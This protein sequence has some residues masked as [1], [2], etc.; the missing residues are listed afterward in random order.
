MAQITY[1]QTRNITNVSGLFEDAERDAQRLWPDRDGRASLWVAQ[2][3]CTDTAATMLLGRTVYVF[4]VQRT[5]YV[6]AP[7]LAPSAHLYGPDTAR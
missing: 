4:K 5:V 6:E 7:G 3:V 1:T 2:N